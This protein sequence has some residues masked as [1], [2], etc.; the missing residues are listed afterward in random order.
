M[1][2]TDTLIDD[3]HAMV[4]GETPPASD[5]HNVAVSYSKWHTPRDKKRDEKV[6]YFSEVGDPCPRK[7][8]FRYN[9]PETSIVT[10]K[11]IGRAHV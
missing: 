8:W 3:I 11:Q 7:L 9:T 1:K 10:G 6:L 5:K 4:R 2:T